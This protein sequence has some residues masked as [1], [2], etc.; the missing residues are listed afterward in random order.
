MVAFAV[1]LALGAILIPG[2]M[3]VANQLKAIGDQ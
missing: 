1:L 2:R 3:V